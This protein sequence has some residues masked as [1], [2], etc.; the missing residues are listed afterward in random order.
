MKIDFKL[1]GLENPSNAN[2]ALLLLALGAA[3]IL[4]LPKNSRVSIRGANKREKLAH[5][6]IPDGKRVVTLR[7]QPDG[8][9]A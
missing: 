9:Y 6:T 8:S 5:D 4:L 7:R 3:A 1:S 2:D